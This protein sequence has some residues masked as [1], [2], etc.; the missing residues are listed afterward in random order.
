MTK[1]LEIS[2][3]DIDDLMVAALEGGINYWCERVKII[4]VN[5]KLHG[6]GEIIASD[7]ISRGGKL[8]LFD[9][10]SEEEWEL[11]REKF[12]KGLEKT[13]EWGDFYS[14]QHLMDSHDA[15]TA[16]VLIQYAL[17]DEITFG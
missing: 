7:V 14:V 9:A 6:N 2:N 3:Q 5:E 12:I 16:D 15:E 13:M 1:K 10:E 11:D 4:E 8:K 17:F